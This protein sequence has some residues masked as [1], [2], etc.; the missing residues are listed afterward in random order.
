[1][2]F[3]LA[4][5]LLNLLENLQVAKWPLNTVTQRR[6]KLGLAVAKRLNGSMV[7]TVQNF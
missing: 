6:V 3:H 7:K 2:Y 4:E 1:M 5:V